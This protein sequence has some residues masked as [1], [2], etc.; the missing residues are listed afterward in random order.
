MANEIT[1]KYK[2]ILKKRLKNEILEAQRNKEWK[3][4]EIQKKKKNSAQSS[5]KNIKG[6]MN[7]KKT[8]KGQ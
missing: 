2:R 5:N 1:W 6:K 8:I 7:Q 3:D 4:I